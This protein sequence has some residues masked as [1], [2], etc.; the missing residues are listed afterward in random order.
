M[1]KR[2][3]IIGSQGNL[4]QD[5]VNIFERDIVWEVFGYDRDEIDV[6][7]EES[8]RKK[9][10]EVSPDAVINASAYNAVDKC[11]T[12]EIEYEL[13]KKINGYG[14]GFLAKICKEK[15]IPLVHYVSD[16]IFDGEKGEYSEIDK[17]NPISNYGR[18]KLLGEEEIRKNTGKFYLIRISKLFGKPG[19][20]PMSKKS[21]FDTMIAFGKDKRVLKVVDDEKSCFT[22]TPDLALETKKIIEEKI[23]F[24]VYHVVNEGACTWYEAAL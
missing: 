18:S 23:P 17:P 2:I 7:S 12:D 13:A 16:Y 11:E 22:Y 9:V 10:E 3:L 21:F 19:T 15:N 1:T 6:T 5:L 20:S 4:G 14:P 8:L 24:G